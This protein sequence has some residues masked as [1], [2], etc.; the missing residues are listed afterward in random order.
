M[1]SISPNQTTMKTLKKVLFIMT[2]ICLLMTCSKS[3]NLF[4]DDLPENGLKSA[5]IKGQ[6]DFIFN[7]YYLTCAGEYVNGVCPTNFMI[8]SHSY[9]EMANLKYYLTG[10]TTGNIYECSQPLVFHFNN[11]GNQTIGSS[12]GQVRLNNKLISV[13]HW[14]YQCTTNENGELVVIKDN[15]FEHCAND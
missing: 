7:H 1:L 8:T 5:V 6:Y 10:E 4:N 14:S 9:K 13:F 3:D 2:G 15:V 12:T 11:D